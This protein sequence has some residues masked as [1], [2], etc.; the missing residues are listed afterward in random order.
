VN[1]EKPHFFSSSKSL[2]CFPEKTPSDLYPH[3][4][5]EEGTDENETEVFLIAY[6]KESAPVNGGYHVF[7]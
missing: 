7:R 3:S 4:Q 6:E 1:V 2:L 5:Q